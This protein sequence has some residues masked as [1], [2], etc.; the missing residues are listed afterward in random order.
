MWTCGSVFQAEEPAPAREWLMLVVRGAA[1]RPVRL[2]Q[3]SGL[4]GC[5]AGPRW[6]QSGLR[7]FPQV[8]GSEGRTAGAGFH[9]NRPSGGCLET[10]QE[11]T[12]VVQWSLGSG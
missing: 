6:P 10:G 7:L 4:G 1:R 5:S 8:Q 3:R 2:R 11:A 12:A 9:G